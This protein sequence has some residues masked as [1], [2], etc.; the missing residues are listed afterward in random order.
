MINHIDNLVNMTREE[1][2]ER[3]ATLTQELKELTSQRVRLH[4]DIILVGS[5]SF[6]RPVNSARKTYVCSS[7]DSQRLQRLEHYLW[8]K[9]YHRELPEK[10][11]VRFID[12]NPRNH[13]LSN[14]ECVPVGK[15]ISEATTGIKKHSRVKQCAICGKTYTPTSANSKVCSDECR[16]QVYVNRRARPDGA[17]KRKYVKSGKYCKPAHPLA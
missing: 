15:V 3:L 4:R 12:N 13:E 1:L 9:V 17:P 8:V 6:T 10:H 14:L 11:V 5:H 7:I 2:D 16:H